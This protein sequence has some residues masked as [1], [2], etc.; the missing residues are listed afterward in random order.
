LGDQQLVPSSEDLTVAI[1]IL[2]SRKIIATHHHFKIRVTLVTN[3]RAKW[4]A[5]GAAFEANFFT[6][7]FA[8]AFV[9]FPFFFFFSAKAT[10]FPRINQYKFFVRTTT[11]FFDVCV[12]VFS[13]F[14]AEF[15]I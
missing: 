5:I 6:A 9:G 13:A 2:K 8:L 12:K 7:G 11:A 10:G 4:V 14:N 3:G 1:F 15:V